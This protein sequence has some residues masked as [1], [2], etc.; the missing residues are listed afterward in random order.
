M[1][2]SLALLVWVD[3]EGALRHKP[4]VQALGHRAR[5][6]E[7]HTAQLGEGAGVEYEQA[8]LLVQALGSQ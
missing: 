1:A 2:G 6:R 7:L 3:L 8:H 4:P 5:S